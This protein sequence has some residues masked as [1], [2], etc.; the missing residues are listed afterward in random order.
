[1]LKRRR[2]RQLYS[3]QRIF[4]PRRVGLAGTECNP[5]FFLVI[6]IKIAYLMRFFLIKKVFC[7]PNVTASSSSSYSYSAASISISF[8]S[9]SSFFSPMHKYL[10]TTQ[11]N[12]PS[13]QE[14]VEKAGKRRDT[15]CFPAIIRKIYT[16]WIDFS[17]P[18]PI[19]LPLLLAKQPPNN[20]LFVQARSCQTFLRRMRRGWR[21]AVFVFVVLVLDS[22]IK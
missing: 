1:M 22:T 14:E 5:H 11:A 21:S 8:L 16:Y 9:F 15:G 3:H 6:C 7:N 2:K 4:F 19:F 17:G 10:H 20:T 18:P 13:I 12:L